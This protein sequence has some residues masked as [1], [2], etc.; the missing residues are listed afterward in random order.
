[1]SSAG[2]QFPCQINIKIMILGEMLKK[3]SMMANI[4]S[5]N[6]SRQIINASEQGTPIITIG[7]GDPKIMIG[8][9]VHGNE[10]PPQIAAFMFKPFK[11]QK[12]K[13]TVLLFLCYSIFYCPGQ[14]IF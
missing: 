1:M 4:P 3:L 8:A 5:S 13:G 11:R 2:K 9:G 6:L 7:S 12:L 14:P 10:L